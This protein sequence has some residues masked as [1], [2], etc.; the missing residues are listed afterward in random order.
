MTGA[1]PF[2]SGSGAG[3]LPAPSVP[4]T[5]WSDAYDNVG[6]IPGAADFPPR[7]TAEAAAFRA[8]MGPRARLDLPY[9][10]PLADAGREAFDLFLPE[11]EPRGLAVFLHGGYWRAFG[12]ETWSHLAAGPLARGWAVAIPSY[13]LAPAARIAQIGAQARAALIAAAEAVPGA[14]VAI[15]GHSAG[16]QLAARLLC[17]DVDLPAPLRARIARAVAISGLFDLRPLLGAGLNEVLRLDA[18]EAAA[19]S[20]AHLPPAPG[21]RLLAWTGAAE[22]PEYLRLARL[23]EA[24]WG[25]EAE[26]AAH[27]APGAHHFDV[28]APLT[29]PDSPL[30]RALTDW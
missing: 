5:D 11:G 6:H 21:A 7:W 24:A 22:R 27:F 18:A 9:P 3:S 14:P 20:P 17:A 16:G 30:T 28:I 8:A 13:T 1:A 15:S 10:G 19:E 29:D 23:I 12:R 26:V 4:V 25:A 2:D